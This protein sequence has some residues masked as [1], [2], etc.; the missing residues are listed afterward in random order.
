MIQRLVLLGAILF[1]GLLVARGEC[2][3]D[4]YVQVYNLI[5][6]ADALNESGQGREAAF[7]YFEAQ[8][9]L[10]TLQT[11]YPGWNGTVVNFRLS[12]IASKLEPLA[13]KLPVTNAPPAIAEAEAP[14]SQPGT[15]QF[16]Q[17]QD[18]IKRLRTENGR[19]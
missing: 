11:E 17:M 4:R 8:K 5:Q 1:S 16:N 13:Q 12:Y 18:E 2:P 14:A 9:A 19:L 10:K 3:E 15:N 7:K 6:E